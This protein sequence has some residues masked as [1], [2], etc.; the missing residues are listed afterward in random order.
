MFLEKSNIF[1]VTLCFLCSF[2]NK[3]FII[4]KNAMTFKMTALYAWGANSH[5]QLG[6]GFVSEQVLEPMR[7][8]DL[9]DNLCES[10]IKDIYGGG[11]HT[12]LLTNQGKLYGA[13]W[14]ISGQ[15]PFSS[16]PI[17][18]DISEAVSIAAGLRHTVIATKEGRVY[19][20]GQG[21][22]GQLGH[23]DTEGKM[24]KTQTTPRVVEPLEMKVK[25]VA[26]GQ[27]TTYAITNEGEVLAWGDNKWG[28]LA[29]DPVNVSF[30]TCPLT[31]P[32]NYFGGLRAVWM[33]AGWTHCAVGLSSGQIYMWGR[34]DYGQVGPVEDDETDEA[35]AQ[36]SKTP[37]KLQNLR[38]RYVPSCLRLDNIRQV[39]CG[40]EHNLAVVGTPE[41]KMKLMS[42]GWN[43]HGNCGTGNTENVYKPVI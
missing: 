40:S 3:N 22:K 38:Y 41:K 7:V 21:Q 16:L 36:I 9:P 27:N 18:L 10:S 13:G 15:V 37:G 25:K 23:L 8:E 19:S 43:E 26:C 17:C 33:Q 14:N 2:K 24:I 28:Q 31:I 32:S 6:L 42:W 1:D 4:L 20:W 30:F 29:H 39:V 35:S 12:F 5:G 34:S 11:G